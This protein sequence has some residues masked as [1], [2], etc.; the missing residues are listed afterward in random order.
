MNESKMKNMV[1]LKNLPSN[2]VEEAYVVLK[3]NKNYKNLQKQ[4]NVDERLS[5][6]YVVKEAEMVISNYLSKIEDKK[7][8]KN[9]EVEKIKKKYKKLKNASMILAGILIL[10]IIINF[11]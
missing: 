3:P 1:V 6:D 4:E 2:I 5:A 7:I 11:I 10:N 9:S 8:I